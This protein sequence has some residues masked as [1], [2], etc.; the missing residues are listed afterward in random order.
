MADESQAQATQ[1]QEP[2]TQE[3]PHGIDWKAE[4]RKWE[5]RAKENKGAADELAKLKEA[6]MTEQ[7]KAEARAQAAEAKVEQLTAEKEHAEAVL[8]ISAQTGVP[9]EFLE[10]CSD[11]DQMAKFCD[12]WTKFHAATAQVVHVGAKAPERLLI[13]DGATKPTSGELFASL[14]SNP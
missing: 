4:A 3:E 1:A 14:F 8:S 2:T 11:A 13:K 12:A 7:Q 6:S 10:Y 5:Q 9:P